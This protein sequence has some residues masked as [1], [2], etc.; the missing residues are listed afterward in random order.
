[1]QYL[2]SLPKHILQ[3]K[4]QASIGFM[5]FKGTAGLIMAKEAPKSVTK[6]ARYIAVVFMLLLKIQKRET[7][8][9]ISINE[10]TK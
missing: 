6:T 9:V 2:T 7:A 3:A 10:G 8:S 4:R 1:M 5:S